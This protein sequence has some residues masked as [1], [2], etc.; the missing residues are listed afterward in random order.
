MGR[1][2]C[3]G[4]RCGH[5]DH[6]LRDSLRRHPSVK[7]NRIGHGRLRLAALLAVA[8]PGGAQAHTTLKGMNDFWSGAFH[9]LLTPASRDV[10]LVGA[11]RRVRAPAPFRIRPRVPTGTRRGAG[12]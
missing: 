7:R 5:L 12:G 3:A 11:R 2:G 9:P 8:L 10:L 4:G 6:R 1:D